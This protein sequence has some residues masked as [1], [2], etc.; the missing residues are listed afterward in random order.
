LACPR[1]AQADF[2]ADRSLRARGVAVREVVAGCAARTSDSLSIESHDPYDCA[3]I[4]F[5]TVVNTDSAGGRSD[6]ALAADQR[7]DV[8]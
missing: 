6:S 7:R 2:L 1:E 4:S 5:A 8:W 3:R